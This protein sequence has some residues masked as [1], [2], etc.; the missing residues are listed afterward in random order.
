MEDVDNDVEIV[1]HDP[2]ARWKTVDRGGAALMLVSQPGL[3]LIGDG[4]QLRLR[5]C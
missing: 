1:E 3:N 4:L 5:R 2:L